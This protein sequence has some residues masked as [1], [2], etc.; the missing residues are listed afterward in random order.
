M[1]ET[2]SFR[3]S[4]SFKQKKTRH[5]KNSDFFTNKSRKALLE[6]GKLEEAIQR[7]KVEVRV[8]KQS[9]LTELKIRAMDN[10]AVSLDKN[11]S[12]EIKKI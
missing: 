10:L 11:F 3:S 1:N 4:V 9:G 5:S 6:M 12:L 8:S 7:H 2:G